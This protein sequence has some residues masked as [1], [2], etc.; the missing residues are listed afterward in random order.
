MGFKEEYIVYPHYKN[1]KGQP[2]YHYQARD[3]EGK[4]TPPK[5]TG[6]VTKTAARAYCEKLRKKGELIPRKQVAKNFS[7]FSKK[8]WDYDNSEYILGKL[9]R[10]QAFGRSHAYNMQIL[11]EK[12]LLPEFGKLPLESITASRVESWLLALVRVRGLS[13]STANKAFQCLKTILGEAFRKNMIFRNPC[14]NIQKLA[15][16]HKTKGILEQ[17]EARL[18]FAR[19]DRDE[20]WRNSHTFYYI[21]LLAAL[22]GMRLGELRALQNDDIQ[23]DED[24]TFFI[25]VNKSLEEGHGLKGTKTNKGRIVILSQQ[26]G[27]EL[28]E[29]AR[30]Q[31]AFFTNGSFLFTVT[32]GRRPVGK[33]QVNDALAFAMACIGISEEERRG[34]NISFHSW[35][36]FA[37]TTYRALGI[38]DSKLQKLTGHTTQAMTEH[39][40][41]FRASDFADLLEAQEGLFNQMA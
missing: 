28:R 16:N 26:L 11:L 10:G 31:K 29:I 39:Y 5:S 25:E 37:N 12:Y 14:E 34:R 6:Q 33:K 7:A 24:G 13:P 23:Q 32:N 2:V 38:A 19:K 17:K 18:L 4:R 21:N 30:M 22:T 3:E 1:K 15:N 41:H 8:F 20:Y 40:S 9:A 35:R 27:A 36:N